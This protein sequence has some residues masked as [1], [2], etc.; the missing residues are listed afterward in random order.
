MPL[1]HPVF[2]HLQVLRRTVGA[3]QHVAVDQAAGAEQRRDGGL[4]AGRHRGVGHPL[5]GLL[6]HEVRVG[7]VLEIHLDG[8]EA[9]ERDRAQRIQPRNA[10]HFDFERNGDQPLHFL[11]GVAGPLR[12]DFHVRRRKIRVGVDRQVLK[13]TARP[14]P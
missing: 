14:R 8:G 4:Q 3:L 1:Q 10:V 9:V 7:A 12:D 6:A 13:R 11:G 5:E 2:D